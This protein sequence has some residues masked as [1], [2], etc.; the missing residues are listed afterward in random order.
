MNG[1]KETSPCDARWRRGQVELDILMVDVDHVDALRAYLERRIRFAL[2]RFSRSIRRVRLRVSHGIRGGVGTEIRITIGLL[3]SERIVL[4][5]RAPDLH[6][7]IDRVVDRLARTITRRMDRS[8][9]T[10][11]ERIIPGERR[12]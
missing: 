12:R 2:A 1:N 4:I 3:S 5:E 7:A 11:L 6:A 10:R 8:R 9:S